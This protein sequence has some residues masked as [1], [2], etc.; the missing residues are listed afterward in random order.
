MLD[1]PQSQFLPHFEVTYSIHNLSPIHPCFTFWNSLS[2]HRKNATV[3]TCMFPGFRSLSTLTFLF[4]FPDAFLP[5]PASVSKS[6][7]TMQ[8]SGYVKERAGVGGGGRMEQA[9]A[10]RSTGVMMAVH[11]CLGQQSSCLHETSLTCCS[12]MWFTNTS[13]KESEKTWF[14][15]AASIFSLSLPGISVHPSF[16]RIMQKEKKK[17]QTK[18]V[19]RLNGLAYT[20]CLALTKVHYMVG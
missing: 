4:Y 7:I 19:P 14:L 8:Y 13:A 12:N 20:Q 18:S 10:Q 15:I 6:L 2:Y 11:T 3:H 5:W 1:R 16:V 9:K 17:C